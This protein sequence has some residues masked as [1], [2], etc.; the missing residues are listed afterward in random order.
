M[1][2]KWCRQS[3]CVCSV[4]GE[5]ATP[6]LSGV[7]RCFCVSGI[8][9][10]LLP[11][12]NGPSTARGPRKVRKEGG[13]TR[14]LALLPSTPWN[15][16][17][18]AGHCGVKAVILQQGNPTQEGEVALCRTPLGLGLGIVLELILHKHGRELWV[19]QRLF[20][21]CSC[22]NTRLGTYSAGRFCFLCSLLSRWGGGSDWVGFP[23]GIPGERGLVLVHWN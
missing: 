19:E 6:A 16:G 5:M 8:S 15:S 10:A 2:L 3:L 18:P 4:C 13:V 1:L 20:T 7:F 12:Q 23:A 21:T 14:G 22:G 17:A 11:R 9:L